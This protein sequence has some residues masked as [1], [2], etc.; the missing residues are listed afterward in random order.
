MRA[1]RPSVLRTESEHR[2]LGQTLA[3]ANPP[4]D[5]GFAAF[6][7]DRVSQIAAAAKGAGF[8][9]GEQGTAAGRFYDLPQPLADGPACPDQFEPTTVARTQREPGPA[10]PEAP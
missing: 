10:G 2:V 9:F 6:E 3:G 8:G 1:T 5:L 4:N 7:F